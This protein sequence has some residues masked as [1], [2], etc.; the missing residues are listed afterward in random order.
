MYKSEAQAYQAIRHMW[1]RQLTCAQRE[2]TLYQ[3]QAERREVHPKVRRMM[4]KAMK[5]TG[6]SFHM[7]IDKDAVFK[8]S[9]A[10]NKASQLARLLNDYEIKHDD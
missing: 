3:W 2:Y 5:M 1:K 9:K 6:L 8:A 7:P 10:R 4:A